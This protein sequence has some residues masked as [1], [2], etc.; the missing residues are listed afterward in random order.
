[1]Q[2]LDKNF[3]NNFIKYLEEKTAILNSQKS[4]DSIFSNEVE[5]TEKQL[6][7]IKKIIKELYERRERKILESSLFSSRNNKNDPEIIAAMLPE[8][9]ALYKA[10]K[11]N[12]ILSKTNILSMLLEGKPPEIKAKALKSE[13]N[14]KNNVLIKFLTEVPKF[15]GNEGT[16]YGPFER[17]D[18]A[19]LP[20]E[21]SKILITKNR[22]KEILTK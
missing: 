17:E 19:A 14:Q 18:I 15:I 4:K 11:D 13:I 2:K 7:N 21:I 20:E 22:A 6:M 3:Y 1:M 12:L 9:I 8:E 5:K 16:V 10:I